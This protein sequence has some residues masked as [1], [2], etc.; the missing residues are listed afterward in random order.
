MKCISCEADIPPQWVNAIKSNICPGCGGPIMHESSKRLL[1]ELAE[2]ME[3]MPNDPEGLAGWLLSNYELRKIGDGEPTEHFHR[4]KSKQSDDFFKRAGVN[5]IAAK[6]AK[7]NKNS[8]LAQLAANIVAMD[9][10][11]GPDE[12][13][14]IDPD[15]EDLEALEAFKKQGL[16]PFV[17]VDTSLYNSSE[18]LSFDANN[19]FEASLMSS[20][21]GREIIQKEKFK[22]IKAQQ[23]LTGGLVKG[24][25]TRGS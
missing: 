18:E 21:K 13:A 15:E 11:D 23:A 17:E 12:E 4:Q 25:F 19:E 8:K 14:Y 7:K 24:G 1:D 22:K 9:N 16:N 20:E 5:P 2:A 3:R 6:L 10:D